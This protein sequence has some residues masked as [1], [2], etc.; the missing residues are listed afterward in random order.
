MDL[1]KCNTVKHDFKLTDN[2]P[3]QEKYRCI[4]HH[5]YQ[6]VMNHLQDMLEIARIGR[7]YQDGDVFSKIQW[8]NV[9]EMNSQT[10][11]AVCEEVQTSHGNIE[12]L[13]H[14]AQMAAH[15]YK[16]QPG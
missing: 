2:Q 14:S 11:Q 8:P 1:G 16:D 5:L 7:N 3:F 12:T 13:S 6:E 15:L 10:V 9:M 4:L